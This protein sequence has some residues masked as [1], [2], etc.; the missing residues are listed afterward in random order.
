MKC[1]RQ[2]PL[3]RAPCLHPSTRQGGPDDGASFLAGLATF[4]AFAVFSAPGAAAFAD[5][6]AAGLAAAL[7]GAG[8]GGLLFVFF[9]GAHRGGQNRRS[10]GRVKQPPPLRRAW[11]TAT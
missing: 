7:A 2:Y 6:L 5:A 1:L 9:L 10:W 11:T 4:S 8:L 3:A